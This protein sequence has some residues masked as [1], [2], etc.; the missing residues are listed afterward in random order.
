M[1][2]ILWFIDMIDYFDTFSFLTLYYMLIF[3][4]LKYITTRYFLVLILFY[5]LF[6]DIYYWPYL[7]QVFNIVFNT[8]S[9]RSIEAPYQHHQSIVYNNAPSLRIL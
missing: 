6:I 5:N 1:P 7:I 9:S 8:F 2:T 4:E 3:I